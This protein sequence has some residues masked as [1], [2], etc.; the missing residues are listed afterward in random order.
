MAGV[1]CR[2]CPSREFPAPRAVSFFSPMARISP[3][4]LEKGPAHLTDL[5]EMSLQGN[6]AACMTV[7]SASKHMF[8]TPLPMSVRA[9]VV[10][11]KNG[12]GSIVCGS[13]DE[14][15]LV[16]LQDCPTWAALVA[17]CLG[18]NFA[19]N[20]C[21]SEKEGEFRLKREFVGYVDVGN[22]PKCGSFNGDDKHKV[23]KSNRL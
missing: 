6:L 14:D 5:V 10:D 1:R 13:I 9:N 15:V 2:V 21:I 8:V 18:S 7:A 20:S 22:P 12:L 17:E 19:P 23:I 11:D 4:K 16:Y 3:S